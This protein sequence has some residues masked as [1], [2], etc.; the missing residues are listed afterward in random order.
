V[1][2][3]NKHRAF[4]KAE[5]NAPITAPTALPPVESSQE[6]TME[7]VQEKTAPEATALTG[8]TAKEMAAVEEINAARIKKQVELEQAE[9]ERQN[10]EPVSI[11]GL[12]A[13]G[14]EVLLEQ[15]RQHA[16]R[17]KPKEYVP[18]PRTERQMT[19]LQEE[20]EAGRR[21]QQRAEAQQASRP[22]PKKDV[23]EGFTT[24]AY[25]PGDLVPDPTIPA[26][27]GVA[28]GTRK[29]GPDAP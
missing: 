4:H 25:R 13:Q 23:S 14:R 18:P 21:T 1:S 28:G 11:I 8:P 15:L 10:A 24:P 9:A 26:I 7:A 20:L 19:Q 2:S 5:L 17:S 29:Y 6:K 16:E 12:A 22:V 27:H 3:K